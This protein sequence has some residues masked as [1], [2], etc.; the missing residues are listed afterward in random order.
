MTRKRE[1]TFKCHKCGDSNYF[2]KKMPTRHPK[3]LVE[4]YQ[5]S[6][7]ESNNDKRLYET[8]FND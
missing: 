3:H 1:R 5:R 4:L 2:A 6:L 7:N 8:H